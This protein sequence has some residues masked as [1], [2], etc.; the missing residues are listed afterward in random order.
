MEP[1]YKFPTYIKDIDIKIGLNI[2][3]N[4]LIRFCRTDK[5]IKSICQDIWKEK[6]HALYQGLPLPVH[7]TNL[8]LLYFNISKSYLQLRLYAQ[9][10]DKKCWIGSKNQ[11]IKLI[12]F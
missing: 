3:D 6:I 4:D 7:V 1:E 12:G 2:N 8:G 9:N 11:L 10:F 5:Y